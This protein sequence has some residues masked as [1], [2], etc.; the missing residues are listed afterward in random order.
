MSDSTALERVEQAL[1]GMSP[2]EK[3]RLLQKLAG[4]LPS[5]C[6]IEYYSALA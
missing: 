4:P 1:A 6:E 2:G 3:A 5:G